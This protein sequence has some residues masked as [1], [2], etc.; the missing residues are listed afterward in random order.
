VNTQS[1]LTA[2]RQ[3]RTDISKAISAK[4]TVLQPTIRDSDQIKK[5]ALS[6]SDTQTRTKT[7]PL[8]GT[9]LNFVRVHRTLR[10]TP[11]M[12]A[13]VTSELWSVEQLIKE[14]LNGSDEHLARV[15]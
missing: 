15:S 13:G 4:R 6:N 3:D 8:P 12:A 1:N 14:A 9:V 2:F 11:A 10:C 5:L 7:V